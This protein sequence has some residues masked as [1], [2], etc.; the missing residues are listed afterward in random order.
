MK[1]H[2]SQEINNALKIVIKNVNVMAIVVTP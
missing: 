2:N 1:S